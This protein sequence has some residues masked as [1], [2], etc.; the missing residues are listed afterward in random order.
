MWIL[1]DC[2]L[3]AYEQ[4]YFLCK[5][6]L[7]SDLFLVKMRFKAFIDTFLIDRLCSNRIKS[8]AQPYKSQVNIAFFKHESSGL[9]ERTEIGARRPVGESDCGLN[10]STHRI[11]CFTTA[12]GSEGTSWTL[13]QLSNTT[14]M[15]S[16]FSIFLCGCTYVP[17]TIVMLKRWGGQLNPLT[18]AWIETF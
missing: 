12:Q 13:H 3:T 6:E 16:V 4:K 1:F 5:Q 8:N 17:A 9:G 14:Q 18:V 11:W 15:C 10:D 7:L 2:F